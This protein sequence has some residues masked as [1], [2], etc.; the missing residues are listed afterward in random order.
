MIP[1]IKETKRTS[2]L[3]A[4]RPEGPVL[5]YSKMRQVVFAKNESFLLQLL[6]TRQTA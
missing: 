5:E 6:P 3:A 1:Q 4:S 2:M